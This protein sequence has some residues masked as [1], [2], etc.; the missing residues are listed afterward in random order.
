MAE[1]KWTKGPYD[2]RHG[3][4]TAPDG[5]VA[6]A[7]GHG[8]GEG[9]EDANGQ[10][11]T[12]LLSAFSEIEDPE[13]FVKAAKELR[14]NFHP[15]HTPTGIKGGTVVMKNFDRAVNGRTNRRNRP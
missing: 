1:Q 15:Y 8:Q 9:V 3:L 11:I 6:E 10:R 5:I 2:Y 13:A 7:R 4:I 14:E 12:V